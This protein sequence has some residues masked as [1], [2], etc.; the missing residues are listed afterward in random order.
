M[1]RTLQGLSST[2]MLNCKLQTAVSDRCTARADR[3]YPLLGAE[4][5]TRR[6]KGAAPRSNLGD[7]RFGY[8]TSFF[9]H[10]VTLCMIY[11]K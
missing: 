2:R 7:D 4:G 5:F 6:G 10:A 1:D 9:A 8:T 3:E 11:S